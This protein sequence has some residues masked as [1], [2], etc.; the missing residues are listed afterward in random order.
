[1]S[2]KSKR[3]LEREVEDLTDKDDPDGGC[4]LLI[5]MAT[6]EHEGKWPDKEES[7]HPELTVR[8]FPERKPKS[9]K[10]AT[11]NV[12]PE[13]YCNEAILTV[14]T[15][16]KQHKYAPDDAEEN[17]PVTACEL[18]NALDEDELEREKAVREEEGEPIPD[19]LAGC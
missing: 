10:I 18:W 2:R 3:E 4:G 17:A 11:P 8:S 6:F 16:D 19:F 9:L 1:M 15:C 14:T 12:L 13:P 7:P 5:N